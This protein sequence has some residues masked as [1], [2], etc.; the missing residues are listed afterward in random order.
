MIKAVKLSLVLFLLAAAFSLRAQPNAAQLA[1]E[2]AVR[3]QEA[4]ITL[5]NK[6]MAAH[7]AQAKGYLVDA[8]KL[9][10]EAVSL[11]PKVGPGTPIVELE[12]KQAVAGLSDVRLQLATAAQRRGNLAEANEQIL[13]ALK[14]DRQNEV[15]L[16]FK[17]ENDKLILAQRGTVPSAEALARVPEVQKEK[18]AAATLV[19]DGKLLWE[20]GKLDEAEVKLKLALQQ[21]P[22][23]QAAFTY[24]NLIKES[25]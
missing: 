18:I 3:R 8:A 14:F 6:L 23:N 7:E 19:Q 5:H 24:L 21:E 20:M 10:Q 9:Y 17:A 25:R 4:T 12:K 16:K 22:E 11:F 15:L 13:S 2:E 1:E